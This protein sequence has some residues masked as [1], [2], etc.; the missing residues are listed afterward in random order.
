MCSCALSWEEILKTWLG[1]NIIVE[2]FITDVYNYHRM[3]YLYMIVHDSSFYLEK[4]SCLRCCCVV[5]YCVA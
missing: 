5:L 3:C 4:K 2:E 1:Y